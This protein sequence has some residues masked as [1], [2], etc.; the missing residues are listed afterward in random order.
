MIASNS[1]VKMIKSKGGG[2]K[3]SISFVSRSHRS[4]DVIW[5]GYKG[6]EVKYTTLSSK[7]S[8]YVQKTY[9]YHP[10]IFKDSDSG[11]RLT[12][13]QD[14]IHWPKESRSAGNEWGNPYTVYIDDPSK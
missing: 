9:V 8:K 3:T 6:E 12:A 2:S 14:L 11:A 4:I 7:G 5:L 10:W 1:I 13:N